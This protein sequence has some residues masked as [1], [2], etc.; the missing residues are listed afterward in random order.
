[1]PCC[2]LSARVVCG[3]SRVDHYNSGLTRA[4]GVANWDADDLQELKD[5]MK[6]SS[7]SWIIMP[8]VAQYRFHPHKSMANPKIA[9]L[10]EFCNA[11]NI[12]FNGYSPLG[13]PGEQTRHETSRS[14]SIVSFYDL[15]G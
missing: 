5:E 7:N 8:A 2:A 13:S 10:I 9:K 6:N 3:S 15:N 14:H 11:N 1:M 4:I 12:T